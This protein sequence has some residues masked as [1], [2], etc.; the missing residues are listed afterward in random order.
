MELADKGWSIIVTLHFN[1]GSETKT[2]G[3]LGSQLERKATH[4][5]KVSQL[6]GEDSDVRK[7]ETQLGRQGNI[8][9]FFIRWDDSVG[10]FTVC[11]DPANERSEAKEKEKEATEQKYIECLPGNAAEV[12]R[13]LGDDFSVNAVR[14]KLQKMADAGIIS[15]DPETKVYSL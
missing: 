5:L 11:E 15:K 9:P 10:G 6:K 2:R 12:C 7:I 4:Q 13:K 3:H 14:N 1:P 8:T